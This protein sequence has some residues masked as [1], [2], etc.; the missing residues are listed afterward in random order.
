MRYPAL[1]GPVPEHQADGHQR[2]RSGQ[3]PAHAV[4]E[5]LLHPGISGEYN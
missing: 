3:I 4:R 2:H 1:G 5:E